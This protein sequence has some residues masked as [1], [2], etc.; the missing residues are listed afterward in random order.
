[1][2]L[3]LTV[4]NIA[5]FVT[6]DYLWGANHTRSL[7][8]ETGQFVVSNNAITG[9]KVA[10]NGNIF[11]SVPRWMSG[12]PSSLNQ[13]VQNPL[14]PGYVLNPWPSWEFNAL[15]VSGSLQYAQSFLIDSQNRMW[16]PDVGRT[17]FFDANPSLVTSGP[18]GIFVLDVE[19]GQVLS[20]YYFPEDIVPYN[21]TFL[22]DLV[23]D[24]TTGFVYIS[25]TYAAG[26][27]L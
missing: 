17:N 16:I 1:M 18:A 4:T 27:C 8:E 14:G 21:N 6:V 22:N 15:N 2:S 11:V 12:V 20:Q 9:I 10:K 3:K 24:E 13:L 5:N 26:I 7:Y 23:L 19:T 25:N